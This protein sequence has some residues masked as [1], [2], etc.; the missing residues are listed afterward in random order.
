MKALDKV[1]EN[2]DPKYIYPFF[3]HNLDKLDES[4]IIILRGFV[5]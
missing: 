2:P 5:N 4:L 1:H 3:E